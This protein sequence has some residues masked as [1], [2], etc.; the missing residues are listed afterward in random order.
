MGRPFFTR[1]HAWMVQNIAIHFRPHDRKIFLVSWGQMRNP[2]FRGF[3]P[4]ECI[5]Q[6]HH[7]VDCENRTNNPRYLVNSARCEVSY[8]YSQIESPYRPSIGTETG[9][10]K[11]PWTALRAVILRYS[12]E[13]DIVIVNAALNNVARPMKH[14][15]QKLKKRNYQNTKFTSD[16]AH[17][18]KWKR[19]DCLLSA[20][21]SGTRCAVR[22]TV[23]ES[24]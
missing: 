21:P 22:A 13:P 23:I 20:V 10:L 6:K 17:G 8:Y 3:T 14:T 24:Q 16:K 9:D 12:T 1:G 11:W 19:S 18:N 5:K 7:P 2:E 4:N 15:K